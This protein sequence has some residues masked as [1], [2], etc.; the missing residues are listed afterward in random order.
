MTLQSAR[1]I[2][3]AA[4]QAFVFTGAG[5]RG[6]HTIVLTC[7]VAG[8]ALGAL[9]GPALA[10]LSSDDIA[11]LRERGKIEGWTFSVGESEATRRPLH[12]LCGLVVPEDWR[13]E[14]R[15]KTP[16]PPRFT[17][18]TFDWRD[19]G[20]CTP[21]RDQGGCGSCW[22]FSAIGAVEC[23]ILINE[24]VSEDLSEQWLVSC[25]DAGSCSGGWHHS[26]FRYLQC[27]CGGYHDP[28][29]D[30]GAVYE[31]D[32]PYVAWDAPCGCPYDHPYSIVSSE[33]VGTEMATVEEIKSAI[34]QHGPV[35]VAVHVNDAFH[36]YSDGVFN[37][38]EEGSIN[39]A[40]VLVGWGYDPEDGGYW[41]LRNSWGTTWGEDGY[42][43]IRYACSWVG[44]ETHYVVYSRSDC[45]GNRIPD[46]CDVGAGTSADCNA[47][48]VP[49]NCEVGV[50]I[51][52]DFN[53]EIE[54]S[55]YLNGSA[56]L[57]A[58]AVRL[59]P[60]ESSQTGSLVFD[61]AVSR[62]MSW[63][64]ASFDFRIGGGSGAEGLSFSAFDADVYSP[65]DVFGE[66][67]P[68]A[69]SLSVEFD[70]YDSGGEND[71][72]LDLLF[73]GV[74]LGSYDPTF[75]LNNN[76]WHHA[77][78]VF[79]GEA[80]T[81][82]LTPNGGSP[83]V[84]YDAVPVP[85]YVPFPSLYG[86]GA[87]TGGSADA[88]W[89]D[90]VLID[91]ETI[92]DCN[93]NGIPDDCDTDCQPNGIPD[94]CDIAGGTSH[95]CQANGIPDEC[96]LDCNTNGYADECDLAAGT[97]DDCNENGWPDECDI[98]RCYGLWDGFQADP[99]FVPYGGV[100]GIDSVVGDESVWD[101]PSS[102]AVIRSPGCE[103]G[104]S[105]DFMVR[106]TAPSAD[107]ESAYVTSEYFQTNHG[108]LPP[109][110]HKYALSFLARIDVSVDSKHDWEFFIYD[111]MSEEAVVQ[112]EFASQAGAANDPGY[113]PGHILVNT[114]EVIYP[115][116]ADT[117]VSVALATCYDIEVALNNL[118]DDAEAVQVYVN[119]ALKVTTKRLHPDARRMDYF[120]VQPVDNVSSGST[121]T[122]FILD[123]FDHCVTGVVVPPS[124]YDCNGNG[125]LDECDIDS[126]FSQDAD[127]N[128]IPD[129]CQSF[130]DFDGDGDVDLVDHAT[131]HG[132]VTGPDGGSLDPGCLFGDSEQDGDVDLEDVAQFQR[133]FTGEL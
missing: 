20:G 30:C 44:Y 112:I 24:G 121:L 73:N 94:D 31:S 35:S 4:N 49:D 53:G 39:H 108:A 55:Y 111:G 23:A 129:E 133:V 122:R 25:T 93:D 50:T 51:E 116:Y 79:D 95:D 124:V 101:N 86:F 14:D 56:V 62:P 67:G 120:R 68:G 21:I 81:V 130:G 90:N 83:E 5:G 127:G 117:G 104:E 85:D 59:T 109:D 38:C 80:A 12:E 110:V 115:E 36:A 78:V 16:P 13:P 42:M 19:L 92:W 84:A 22:A 26:A 52:E 33:A 89:V 17:P 106:I 8:F 48:E 61:A 40:V 15:K 113:V 43:R 131:F 69:A 27:N 6:V 103:T 9:A 37:A 76:Q 10:Q 60:A 96:D 125:T 66:S 57:S 72:H 7:L 77:S 63:F 126:G 123:Q 34:Y 87:R 74:S 3:C 100:H 29:G 114:N 65:L 45:N 88:H 98:L 82:T 54:S 99:P 28:C 107:P 64:S 47:N 18:P 102:S 132:C 32:F 71:N 2:D 118:H 41:I 97:S 11:A 75:D 91:C 1:Y 70:T 46:E 58:G 128:G 119:G 105:D